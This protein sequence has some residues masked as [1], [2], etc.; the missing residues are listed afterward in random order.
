MNLISN[1][2][3]ETY[4]T[5][6]GADWDKTVTPKFGK[7]SWTIDTKPRTDATPWLNYSHEFI[8][9]AKFVENILGTLGITKRKDT[10]YDYLMDNSENVYR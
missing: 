8:P 6:A 9:P 1:T 7:D 4:D 3:G 2:F 10:L 5:L